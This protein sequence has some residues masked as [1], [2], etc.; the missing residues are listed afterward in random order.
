MTRTSRIA[1]AIGVSPETSAEALGLGDAPGNE[2]ERRLD[3]LAAI[4]RRIAPRFGT[5]AE[6]WEWARTAPL[7]GF[8]GLTAL[9]LVRR[10]RATDVLETVDAVDAGVH[11]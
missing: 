2:A 6:A 9:D 10:D 5:P 7:P 1:D 8:G 4:W 3:D 11:A